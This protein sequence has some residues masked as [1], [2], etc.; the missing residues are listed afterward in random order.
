MDNYTT[1]A[2]IRTGEKFTETGD[3]D[4][5]GLGVVWWVKTG[6]REAMRKDGQLRRNIGT[7]LGV[8]PGWKTWD[9]IVRGA[10][11]VDNSPVRPELTDNRELDHQGRLFEMDEEAKGLSNC[12]GE[13]CAAMAQIERHCADFNRLLGANQMGADDALFM[14]DK[15]KACAEDIRASA[16]ESLAIYDERRRR[17][18]LEP[19]NERLIAD[20]GGLPAPVDDY[21][22][23]PI[24]AARLGDRPSSPPPA[25]PAPEP[26]PG[27]KA[28][29][30][31]GP[32]QFNSIPVGSFFV[33]NVH[34]VVYFKKSAT[35]AADENGS[36][37]F[38]RE[39]GIVY[40]IDP[41]ERVVECP[42]PKG[43][44]GSPI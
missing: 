36:P 40:V 5:D 37:K 26:A 6:P 9:E 8:Y 4:G 41:D 18:G 31:R 10:R 35:E 1:F 28:F 44:F 27:A 20:H 34:P 2:R 13:A 24:A 39:I 38:M 15:I 25:P 14:A 17:R 30:T 16:I 32:F 33:L 29:R 23:E 19:R 22:E 12:A 43:N 7:R 11:S 3:K 42:S 21:P